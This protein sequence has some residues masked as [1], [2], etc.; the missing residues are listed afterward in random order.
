MR[1]ALLAKVAGLQLPANFLDVLIAELGGAAAVAEMTGRKG[2]VVKQ[3]SLVLQPACNKEVWLHLAFGSIADG[4]WSAR[5]TA[6]W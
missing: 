4:T 2:R 5:N 3:V 6:Q 1:Q